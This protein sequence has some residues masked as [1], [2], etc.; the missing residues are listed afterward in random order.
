[1][2]DL[3]GSLLRIA[4]GL[5]AGDPTRREILSALSKTANWWGVI[6]VVPTSN[7]K[8][9]TLSVVGEQTLTKGSSTGLKYVY[10]RIT[11]PIAQISKDVKKALLALEPGVDHFVADSPTIG[12]TSDGKNL[13]AGYGHTYIYKDPATAEAAKNILRGFKGKAYVRGI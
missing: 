1:M 10:D 9:L 12:V 7:P 3:R 2:A 6:Q 11:G 13:H 8:M 5:P 4:S